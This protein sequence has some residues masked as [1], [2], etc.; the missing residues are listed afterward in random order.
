M[1]D[2]KKI[3]K[4]ADKELALKIIGYAGEGFHD[5]VEDYKESVEYFM[6]NHK[7]TKND[8]KKGNRA[9]NKYAEIFENRIS[10]LTEALPD[11]N[12]APQEE[13]DLW[14]AY[15]LNQVI[16]DKV[17]KPWFDAGE[18]ERSVE[19]AAHAGTSYIKTNVN[20]ATG[21]PVF[22]VIPCG[23]ILT[24]RVKKH[25]DQR[26]IVHIYPMSIT[27]IKKELGFDV[28]PEKA[29]DMFEE[30][31]EGASVYKSFEAYNDT[32][33]SESFS[34][35]MGK[36]M[37]M[38]DLGDIGQALVAEVWLD[39]ETME[40]IPFDRD[41][42]EEILDMLH[43][44]NVGVDPD[45]NHV[46]AV[47]FF[48]EALGNTD[49]ETEPTFVANLMNHIQLHYNYPMTEKRKKYPYGKVITVCQGNVRVDP[50]PI[51]IPWRNVFLHWDFFRHP[52][53]VFGKGLGKDLISSQDTLNHRINAITKNI[54]NL[55]NGVVLMRQGVINAMVKLKDNIRKLKNK[56]GLVVPVTD[57]SRD[58]K[59]DYGPSLQAHHF[60]EVDFHIRFMESK[61][62]NEGL[63]AGRLP[64]GSPSGV[65]VEQL[66][67]ES[68]KPISAV[69]RRFSYMIKAM[70]INAVKVMSQ[71]MDEDEIFSILETTDDEANQ[72][73]KQIRWGDLKDTVFKDINVDIVGQTGST[74]ARRFV[75]AVRLMEIGAYRAEDVLDAI[76]DPKKYKVMK[77]E[78]MIA[79]LQTA[80]DQVMNINGNL[81]KELK[82]LRNRSQGSDGQGNVG[83]KTPAPQNV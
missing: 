55:N 70:A 75:E 47:K 77:R 38:S 15:A 3:S 21:Y 14:K 78:N 43:K 24:D 40:R 74:R 51:N 10:H 83:E 50:N 27:E 30:G 52:E 56:I 63:S 45:D 18:G 67:G 34:D 73:Y 25:E 12:F 54:N 29:L 61:S 81:E 48:E 66:L 57:V 49:E 13:S 2:K 7:I 26:F 46:E 76:D 6:G 8:E 32:A 44:G 23:Q 19:Q 16:R 37:K 1:P 82:T 68:R 42:A 20:K 65:T 41:R 53:R 72:Q 59:R 5:V 71:F 80:L 58:F 35:R 33:P 36:N 22:T 60:M 39:D 11:I 64:P 17:I 31:A 28:R 79:Q 4:D 62:G 9:Y 69:I